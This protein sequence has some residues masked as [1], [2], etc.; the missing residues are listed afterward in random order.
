MTSDG[1]ITPIKILLE[2]PVYIYAD[3]MYTVV[4]VIKGPRTYMV[5]NIRPYCT[6]FMRCR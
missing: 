3:T 1:G 2:N 6:W 5:G 4:A